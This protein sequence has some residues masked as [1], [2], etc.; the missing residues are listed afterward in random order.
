MRAWLFVLAVLATFTLVTK[1]VAST[2]EVMLPSS[3]TDTTMQTK[4][5]LSSS[6][7]TSASLELDTQQKKE[8]N[9]NFNFNTNNLDNLNK[10]SDHKREKPDPQ[11]LVQIEKNLLSLFGF[12]KQ[13]NIDRSKV[14]IPDAMK[15]LYA[16]IMGHELDSLNVPRPGLHTKNANTVRSF[17]HEGELYIIFNDSNKKELC[18]VK[19]SDAQFLFFFFF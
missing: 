11:T 10:N 16:Q 8:T 9:K 2:E 1:E 4:Q 14:I 19:I 3:L 13:P 5:S 6:T 17:T 7:E 18:F 15:Q 12:K